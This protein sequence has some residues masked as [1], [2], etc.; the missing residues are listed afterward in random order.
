MANGYE[1]KALET[2]LQSRFYVSWEG[3]AESDYIVVD[4]EYIDT[5][6]RRVAMAISR[7]TWMHRDARRAAHSEAARRNLGHYSNRRTY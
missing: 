6:G 4:G 2:P 5:E 3:H 1:N 7:Y